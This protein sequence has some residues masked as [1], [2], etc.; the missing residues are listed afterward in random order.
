[1]RG[2][3]QAALEDLE[4]LLEAMAKDGFDAAVVAECHKHLQA[5]GGSRKLPGER[6]VPVC[7]MRILCAAFDIMHGASETVLRY[8]GAPK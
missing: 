1:M 5:A 2:D 3:L 7:F 8:R 6:H 4:P